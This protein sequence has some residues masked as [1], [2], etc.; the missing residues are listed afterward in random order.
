MQALY[1]S[2][3]GKIQNAEQAAI[4]IDNRTFR[5]GIGLFETLLAI[6]NEVQQ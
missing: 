4:A 2:I 3:N 1:V 6:N 5:Y